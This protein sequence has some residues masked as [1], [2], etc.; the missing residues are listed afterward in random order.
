MTTVESPVTGLDTGVD[1]GL[2]TSQDTAPSPGGQAP[3]GRS[4]LLR[5]MIAVVVCLALGWLIY[6]GIHSRVQAEAALEHVAQSSEK[7]SVIVVHP[8]AGS[9][10]AEIVLPGSTQ[11][12]IDTPIYARTSGYLKSWYTDIGAHVKQGQVLAEIET[13]ELDQQL[14]Q[15][16]AELA[17]AQANAKLA[18]LNSTRYQ[19]LLSQNAV[20]K[21]D[22]DGFVS[23]A[24]ST[25]ATVDSMMANVSRLEQLQSFEKVVAPYDGVITAR[26]TDIGALVQAGDSPG[27]KEL[28]HLSSINRLRIY[29]AVPEVDASDVRTGE[30]VPL[31][32]D[33]LPG[34]IF[35]GT[36]VRDSDAIDPLS[37]T[38]NVEVD[39]DNPTGRLMPGA[40]ASVHLPVRA[41]QGAV[42]IP[43]ST[44]LFRSQ[45]MQVGVVSN[46]RVK[47][48]PVTIGHDYGSTVEV[49]GGLS[50]E[51]ALVVN[52]SDSLENGAAVE[53]EET[54]PDPKG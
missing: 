36:L 35:T 16:R 26:S 33:T 27:A 10:A 12:F 51:D 11:A 14:R 53:I 40:Y 50:P 2:Y 49:I 3:R 52:P 30:K 4:G 54:T 15:A 20:T 7:S 8:Q 25:S 1:A 28:F 31:T 32:I 47:L 44:L 18:K 34:Q 6:S 39:V 48:V 24:A 19:D 41:T 37:R 23:Q 9:A 38:L 13:P 5:W 17:T 29:I 22:T 43:S 46:G 21:Q 42:T 45:G